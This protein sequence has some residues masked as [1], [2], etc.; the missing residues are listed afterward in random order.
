MQQIA[1]MPLWEGEL[2]RKAEKKTLAPAVEPYTW[3]HVHPAMAMYEKR[4]RD[5]LRKI[6]LKG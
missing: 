6:P 4:N 2:S 5:C 1:S 3:Q